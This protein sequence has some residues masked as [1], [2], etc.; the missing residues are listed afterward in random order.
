MAR[1]IL[2]GHIFF[3]T[4]DMTIQFYGCLRGEK[5]SDLEI[6]KWNY[7]MTNILGVEIE[8]EFGIKYSKSRMEDA[9]TSVAHKK[10]I[11]LPAMYMKSFTYDGKEHI[12]K[13]LSK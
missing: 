7:H 2:S 12:S 10:T 4:C 6:R 8:K 3:D 11:N 9:I 1:E 5:S 13:F